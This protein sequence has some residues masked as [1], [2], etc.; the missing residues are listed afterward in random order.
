MRYGYI[1]N[2]C[3]APR[4]YQYITEISGK[5]QQKKVI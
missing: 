4:R 2:I 1:V 5:E 3:F